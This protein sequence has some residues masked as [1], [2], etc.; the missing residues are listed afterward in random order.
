MKRLLLIAV[1]ITSIVG[2]M[3]VAGPHGGGGR[4]GRHGGGG[5]FA[6]GGGHGGHWNHGGG[7]HWGGHWNHRG[8]WRYGGRWGGPRLWNGFGWGLWVG[9]VYCPPI[10]YCRANPNNR[11]CVGCYGY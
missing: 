8:F 4:G 10:A 11:D 7:G 3:L 9:G 5:H 6:H 1:C 2:L